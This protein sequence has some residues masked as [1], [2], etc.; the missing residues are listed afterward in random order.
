MTIGL[1]I[2]GVLANFSHAF[3]KRAKAR[4][5]DSAF[6][7]HWTKWDS[8]FPAG[9]EDV[10]STLFPEVVADHSFWVDEV[11]PHDDA[12]VDFPVHH[13]VTARDVPS[14]VTAE[15]LKKSGFPDAPVTSVGSN[16]SKLEVL[17]ELG[18]DL[19][20]DDK[21]STFTEL[22]ENGVFCLLMRRP[23]NREL[24]SLRYSESGRVYSLAINYL[25]DVHN[26]LPGGM[27]HELVSME[28]SA[29][30]P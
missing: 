2:D 8:W 19:F 16:D 21:G 6:P 20:V 12:Y 25:A 9:G 17:R 26:F 5:P 11:M 14:E 27:Y 4:F 23:H 24:N 10:F 22:N 15:W 29:L 28:T 18:V 7:K 1:D 3:I 13:Y 30:T